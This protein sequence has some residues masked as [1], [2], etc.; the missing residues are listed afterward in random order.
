MRQVTPFKKNVTSRK[1]R[2]GN[3]RARISHARS[4]RPS[5]P[6]SL[7]F[8]A[9]AA[10]GSRATALPTF[11]TVSP[12]HPRRWEMLPGCPTPRPPSCTGRGY[13]SAPPPTEHVDHVA[14]GGDARQ[15]AMH[16]SKK[17][18]R[19][20]D[21]SALRKDRHGQGWNDRMVSRLASSAACCCFKAKT[22]LFSDT[23]VEV[24]QQ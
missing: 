13:L 5:Q 4:T 3:R 23:C 22:S 10:S 14:P 8:V 21:S 18:S 20:A 12:S 7:S 11:G 9:S 2:Q 6:R 24:A 17:K 19:N 1:S 15:P 16:I